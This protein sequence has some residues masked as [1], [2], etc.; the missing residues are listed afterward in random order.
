M[1][2]IVAISQ[3]VILMYFNLTDCLNGCYTNPANIALYLVFFALHGV[4]TGR[5]LAQG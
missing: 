3:W 4:V 5:A 1:Y 2:K